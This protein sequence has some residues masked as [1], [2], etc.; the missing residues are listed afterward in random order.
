[1]ISFLLF[2]CPPSPK[3]NSTT[4]VV[5]VVML[6]P[7]SASSCANSFGDDGSPLH[8]SCTRYQL[9]LF[10]PAVPPP[11]LLLS[12]PRSLVQTNNKYKYYISRNQLQGMVI[13]RLFILFILFQSLVNIVFKEEF[14]FWWRPGYNLSGFKSFS[15]AECRCV[16][17]WI[18]RLSYSME[19]AKGDC[20]A[21]STMYFSRSLHFL[22]PELPGHTC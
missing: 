16:I 15:S 22:F 8:N 17:I 7:P 11:L 20:T 5:L 1:M 21:S 6:R 14:S 9:R 19:W 2:E 3:L 13:I 12:P 10:S 18:S 4:I